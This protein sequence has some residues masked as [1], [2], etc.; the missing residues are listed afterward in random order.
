MSLFSNNN[1]LTKSSP[2][3]GQMQGK[4]SLPEQD[5]GPSCWSLRGKTVLL[6]AWDQFLFGEDPR[7]RKKA[8]PRSIL[9]DLSCKG[10]LV[11]AMFFGASIHVER[12]STSL[13]LTDQICDLAATMYTCK[14]FV[15]T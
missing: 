6:R 9:I 11:D 10:W 7:G 8:I 12:R 15:S 14:V 3:Q 5:A 4:S 2:H 13:A 1:D